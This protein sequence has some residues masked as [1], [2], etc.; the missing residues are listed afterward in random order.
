M[1]GENFFHVFP[2]DKQWSMKQKQNLMLQCT[3]YNA[4]VNDDK[5]QSESLTCIHSSGTASVLSAEV[6]RQKTRFNTMIV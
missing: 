3:L 2:F 1:Q 4:K 6:I 5:F